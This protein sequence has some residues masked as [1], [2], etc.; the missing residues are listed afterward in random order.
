MKKDANQTR[1]SNAKQK[2]FFYAYINNVEI[3]M[4]L[5]AINNNIKYGY[6]Y[7]IQIMSFI[8]IGSGEDANNK[9]KLDKHLY[10]ILYNN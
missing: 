1:I 6:I 10:E 3:N 4:E 8:Y 9:S 5:E 7:T 2:S